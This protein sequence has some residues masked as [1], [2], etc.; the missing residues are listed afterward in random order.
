METF[1]ATAAGLNFGLL[2]LWWVVVQFKYDAWLTDPARRRMA[3]DISLYFLLPGIMSLASLLATRETALW[4]VGFGAAALIGI[5]ET[6]RLLPALS[7]GGDRVGLI[8]SIVTVAI[9]AVVLLVAFAP[10]L[11]SDLGMNLTA[12]EVEGVLLTLLLFLGVNL[13]WRWFFER[14]PPPRG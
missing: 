7:S 14:T 12:L 3:Y 1:Y 11:P 9:Y 5:I 13:V 8:S 10:K 6:A 2:G 4:R